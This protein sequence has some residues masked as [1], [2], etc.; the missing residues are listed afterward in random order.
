MTADG[1]KRRYIELPL[2]VDLTRQTHDN[3]TTGIG[4]IEPSPAVA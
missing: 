1:T 4:A 3:R 2:R